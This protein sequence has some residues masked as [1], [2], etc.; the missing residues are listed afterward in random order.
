MEEFNINIGKMGG[1]ILHN[2]N[3]KLSIRQF[4][5]IPFGIKNYNNKIGSDV[6][7]MITKDLEELNFCSVDKDTKKALRYLL[8][9]VRKYPTCYF[10]ILL[11]EENSDSSELEEI[12]DNINLLKNTGGYE[13]WFNLNNEKISIS[14]YSEALELH[15]KLLKQG[16]YKMS[17]FFL[18]LSKKMTDNP[19]RLYQN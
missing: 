15:L 17:E 4:K 8:T 2:E 11:N 18:E 13:F 1:N 19:T 6:E 14:T 10:Y 16:D 5:N 9:L 12:N 7:R 3:L